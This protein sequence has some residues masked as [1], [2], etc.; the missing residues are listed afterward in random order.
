MADRFHTTPPAAGSST[1][2]SAHSIRFPTHQQQHQHPSMGF[3][4][5]Q[6][7]Q[8]PPFQPATPRKRRRS[9][10]N[11]AFYYCPPA[12]AHSSPATPTPFPTSTSYHT[13]GT[14]L[15]DLLSPARI[16]AHSLTSSSSSTSSFSAASSSYS[17]Q[18]GLMAPPLAKRPH[19]LHRTWTAPVNAFSGASLP[20]AAPNP[21]IV[22]VATSDAAHMQS[23]FSAPSSTRTSFSA[24]HHTPPSIASLFSAANRSEPSSAMVGCEAASAPVAGAPDDTDMST[25]E[26]ASSPSNLQSPPPRLLS[27]ASVSPAASVQQPRPSSSFSPPSSALSTP[28]Q[29]RFADSTSPLATSASFPFTRRATLGHSS[30]APTAHEQPI[31]GVP[32][33]STRESSLPSPPAPMLGVPQPHLPQRR[34][35]TSSLGPAPAFGTAF[36][37]SLSAQDLLSATT[38][39]LLLPLPSSPLSALPQSAGVGLAGG[40][41]SSSGASSV[42]NNSSGGAVSGASPSTP[43][44]GGGTAVTYAPLRPS[45]LIQSHTLTPAI[46]SP[47][48]RSSNSSSGE[49]FHHSG[50]GA[51]WSGSSTTDMMIGSA[52]TEGIASNHSHTGATFHLG[53]APKTRANA[54]ENRGGDAVMGDQG[55]A[56]PSRLPFVSEQGSEVAYSRVAP[57]HSAVQSGKRRHAPTAEPDA[58]HSSSDGTRDDSSRAATRS[59]RDGGERWRTSALVDSD[60]SDDDQMADVSSSSLSDVHSNMQGGSGSGSGSGNGVRSATASP[61]GVMKWPSSHSK[62]K[63]ASSA[64]SSPSSST[65]SSPVRLGRARLRTMP[66]PSVTARGDTTCAEED[67]SDDAEMLTAALSNI[68]TGLR[69]SSMMESSS[70]MGDKTVTH[71]VGPAGTGSSTAIPR[72]ESSQIFGWPSEGMSIGRQEAEG[73]GG[74]STLTSPT[75]STS[76][77]STCTTASGRSSSVGDAPVL[78]SE[79]AGVRSGEDGLSGFGTDA[80]MERAFGGVSLTSPGPSQQASGSGSGSGM[81]TADRGSSVAGASRGVDNGT[82]ESAATPRSY[83]VALPPMV[84]ANLSTAVAAA[85]SAPTSSLASSSSSSVRMPYHQQHHHQTPVGQPSSPAPRPSPPLVMPMPRPLHHLAFGAGLGVGVGVGVTVGPGASGQASSAPTPVSSPAKWY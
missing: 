58:S 13:N 32:A 4:Q 11:A 59:G 27:P 54:P 15:K 44:A 17:H 78:G 41:A 65:P 23:P 12:D 75:P 63:S 7:Q 21:P 33:F 34:T 53:R 40:T 31:F 18:D 47:P 16:G 37:R 76:S 82:G 79:T 80:T 35:S 48:T 5:Q 22:V 55:V 51:F 28:W 45:P 62:S 84:A 50:A 52:G 60:D 3:E 25:D 20:I 73:S 61:T 72:T 43:G 38:A 67:E 68:D 30:A 6:H 19:S 69:T 24:H 83:P 39:G 74:M 9:E 29:R 36:S 49:S 10:E 56:G 42:S 85:V 1:S 64:S 71:A 57:S 46:D 81:S 8:R 70:E 77:S 26:S 2:S 66:L 14:L